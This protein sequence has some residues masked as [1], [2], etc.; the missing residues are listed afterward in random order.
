LLDDPGALGEVAREALRI[1]HFDPTTGEDLRRAEG[2]RE[3]CEAACYDCLMTYG[4]QGD[5]ALLDRHRVKE[6][7]LGLTRCTVTASPTAS[8]FAEHLE[9]LKSHTG[10]ELERCWLDHLAHRGLHLPS[11][12]QRLIARVGTRPDFFYERQQVAIYVDGPI[13]DYLDRQH[14]DVEATCRMEDAGYIVVR[15]GHRDDW[16]AILAAHSGI[17]GRPQP[18]RPVAADQQV[19]GGRP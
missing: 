5:H 11:D 8:T 13:H 16:D 19:D 9:S 7:L 14:R 10:S 12:A 6:I 2:S 15:F 1:C 3:D 17:F 4:N 18:V